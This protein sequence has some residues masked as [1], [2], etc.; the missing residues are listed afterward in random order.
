MNK[1]I[2]I[3][4]PTG[5]GKTKLSIE[6]AKKLNGEVINADS[7]QVYKNL[8]IATAKV[9]IEEMEGIPHHLINIKTIED[10]YTVYHYQQD[11]RKVIDE[12]IR[13]KKTPIMVGGTGLYVK[14]SLYDYEFEE[15]TK[16]GNYKN[17]SDDDLYNLLLEKDPNTEIHKNNRKRVERAL[18]YFHI[19]NKPLS[20][21]KK[22]DRLLYDVIFI[23]LT[24]SRNILYEKINNRVDKM[25]ELGLLEEAEYIYNT[26]VR[27]K[28][29]MTPIGYKELF[30]YFDGYKTLEESID[31]I[32][33]RSRKYA[34]RQYTWF[35]NQMSINWFNTNYDDF[36]KTVEEILLFINNKKLN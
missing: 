8:D 6:L 31:L 22:T 15:E 21:K 12:I 10:D 27:T 5:V 28:A 13:N 9:T 11:S 24:T 3:V 35:N 20:S 18:D 2:V 7:T 16:K 23:G 32:K 29:V 17:Y 25:I 34:K 36:D 30:D 19:N 4:G 26:N 14:A 1:V 33:K